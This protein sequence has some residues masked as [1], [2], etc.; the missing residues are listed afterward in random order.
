V[1][2]FVRHGRT[3]WN[4]EGRFQGWS[5]GGLDDVGWEQA[6]RAGEVVAGVA[7]RVSAGAA[8]VWSSDLARARQTAEVVAAALGVEITVTAGLREADVGRWAG[9]ARAEVEVQEPQ[10]HLAWWSGTR[11]A[12]G[13]SETL[14]QAGE[15]VALSI[16]RAAGATPAGA[17]LVVVGHGL[18]LRRALD[19]LADQGHIALGGAAPHLGNGEV[20]V[21]PAGGDPARPDYEAGAG[22][23]MRASHGSPG[24]PG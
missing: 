3:T 16:R 21:L 9:R 6:G 13:G 23:T 1:L 15:R 11:P 5:G 20:L 10:A 24:P 18:S 17:I 4:A 19:L 12:P 8:R 14:A 2:V 22:D 7:A